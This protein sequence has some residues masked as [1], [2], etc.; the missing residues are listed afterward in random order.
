[1]SGCGG[2]WRSFLWQY[3]RSLCFQMRRLNSAACA[4]RSPN[5]ILP[6]YL[7]NINIHTTEQY[8]H[9]P[10]KLRFDY[11]SSLDVYHVHARQNNTNKWEKLTNMSRLLIMWSDSLN[12]QII[13][14]TASYTPPWFYSVLLMHTNDIL[15]IIKHQTLL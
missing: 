1:M 5:P 6:H 15:I 7:L 11:F 4:F 12:Y 10:E 9:W 2:I 14:A 13:S 8:S 3:S